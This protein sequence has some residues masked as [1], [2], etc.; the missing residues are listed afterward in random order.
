MVKEVFYQVTYVDDFHRK[1]ITF[2]KGFSAVRF[3]M[4]R[5][6]NVEFEM[7]EMNLSIEN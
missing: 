7:T 1:H 6:D 3:L 2:V 4:E 5:F